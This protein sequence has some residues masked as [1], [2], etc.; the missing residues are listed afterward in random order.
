[1]YGKCNK[2]SRLHTIRGLKRERTQESGRDI[3]PKKKLRG[4][5]RDGQLIYDKQEI[6]SLLEEV[7][8]YPQRPFHGLISLPKDVVIQDADKCGDVTCS[9]AR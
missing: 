2:T 3:P 7:S 5:R 1:M 9:R 6:R 4:R 8:I